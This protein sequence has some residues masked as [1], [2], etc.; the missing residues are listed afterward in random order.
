MNSKPKFSICFI[1]R[2]EGKVLERALKSLEAFKHREGEVCYLDTGSTDNTVEI[3]DKWGCVHASVGDKFRKVVSKELADKV[4]ERFIV[5]NE[6][7][8]LKEGDSYFDFA[9]ARNYC[10]DNLATNDMVAF[11]DCDEGITAMDIDEINK[12]IDEGF[13]QFEYEFVFS[14]DHNNNPLLQFVQS[15]FY[16]KKMMCWKGVVHEVLQPIG[17]DEIKR[18]YLPENIWKNE[19]WQNHETNRTGYLRGLAIDC[20]EHPEKDRNSHYFAREIMWNGRYKS[21]IKE[22]KRYLDISWWKPERSESMIY[23]GDCLKNLKKE[24]EAVEWYH[25]AFQEEGGRREPLIRLAEYYMSK[26][27]MQRVACYCKAALEIPWSGYYSNNKYHYGHIPHEMMA[28]AYWC[29]GNREEAKMHIEKALDYMPTNGKLLYDYRFHYDLPVI[30][31]IIPTLGRPE[32]LKRCLNSIKA[33]NYPQDKI[34]TIVLEDNPRIGVPKRV[35]EG[36]EKSKGEYIVYGANDCE[37][38]PDS[39]MIAFRE[40]KKYNALLVAFNTGEVF[41][42]KGNINEHFMIQR[43]YAIAPDGLNYE[44]FDLEMNHLGV[45]NILWAKVSKLNRAHRSK[46]A[47]VNHYHWS[48]PGGKMDEVYEIA[49]NKEAVKKDRELLKTKLANLT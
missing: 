16:N 24:D 30:S 27:D 10:A 18:K 48:K 29:L 44:I 45:D 41:P 17:K 26:R 49:W 6:E 32:G 28:E 39:L 37:F 35:K 20:Y 11:L 1:G 14:H 15:K 33:L 13:G 9:S 31:F 46:D 5:E 38:T 23:I 7:K 4:N 22:F 19:H 8:I 42:D 21:A 3:A 25:K 40:M 43:Q 12:A 34:E 36:L 47:I 2:N